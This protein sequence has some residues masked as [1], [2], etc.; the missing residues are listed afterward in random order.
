MGFFYKIKDYWLTSEERFI[1]AAGAGIAMLGT[2]GFLA[3]WYLGIIFPPFPRQ[4]GPVI[5]AVEK[6]ASARAIAEQ[7]FGNNLI[8]SRNVFLGYVKIVSHEG[9]LRSGNFVFHGPL[10]VPAVLAAM[11]TGVTEKTIVIPEGWTVADIA[12]YL[13]KE[14][15]FSKEQ[16]IAAAESYE[17]Y[18][19]PDTYQVFEDA[20]PQD[21]VILMRNNFDKKTAMYRDSTL[22]AGRHGSIVTFEDVVI[23]AS[24]LEK[25]APSL[26]DRKIVAGIFWKRI[27]AG[28]PLQVDASLTYATGRASLSLTTDDLALDSPYNTYR[29]LGLPLGPIANPGLKSLEAALQPTPS[30]YWYYLSDREGLLHYS[31]TFEEHREKKFKYLR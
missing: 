31:A 13:E 27:E 10:S 2:A 12:E 3:L 15:F 20:S 7:L 21:I 16:F 17:G 28:M 22:P 25:E 24:L 29:K 26:G 14:D 19:F 5:V 4:S 23:M 1:I 9:L 11:K 18:L 30:S 8:R 6:G